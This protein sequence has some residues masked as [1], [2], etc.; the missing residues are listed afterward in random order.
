MSDLEQRKTDHLDLAISGDV[1][2]RRT[3][4]L[5]HVHL[6]HCSLPELSLD[7][8]DLS[9]TIAGVRCRSPLMIAS[10]TGGNTRAGQV[11]LLLAEVAEKGGY[12][13]GLGSQRAMVKGGK[14]DAAVGK[15]YR[16]RDVAPTAPIFANLGVVQAAQMPT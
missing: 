1:G 2:F 14:I 3:S 16:L 5:E 15:S 12:P 8:V 4:L 7:E 11:N 6:L 10:M 13:I 9:T